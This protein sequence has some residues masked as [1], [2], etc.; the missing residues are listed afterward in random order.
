L[1]AGARAVWV[2]LTSHVA[3]DGSPK[4]VE[5]CS[6]PLT[7][8]ACVDR[9]YSDLAVIAVTADG[10]LV[11]DLLA[12]LAEDELAARTG[13]PLRFAPDCRRLRA[14]DAS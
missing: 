8:L 7:G 10:F 13:A 2:M 11:T 3:K 1:V 5:R 6:L 14:G 12:G 9:V 4:L